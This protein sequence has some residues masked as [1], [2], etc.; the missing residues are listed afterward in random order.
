MC[1]MLLATGD[2]PVEETLE[3]AISMA[4]GKTCPH[5]APSHDHPHG[6]G[7]V[8]SDSD[9]PTGYT[10]FKSLDPLGIQSAS[11]LIAQAG[12]SL[13]R[14]RLLAV[15]ARYATRPRDMGQQFSHPLEA[16]TA[17]GR[18]YFM[19]N[20]FLPFAYQH[21]GLAESRFDT[22]E[23]FQLVQTLLQANSLKQ[24]LPEILKPMGKP[25]SAANMIFISG[26]K[27]HVFNWWPQDH[28]FSDYFR[29]QVLE[30]ATH[31]IISS[32]MLPN[33][34]AQNHWHAMGRGTFMTFNLEGHAP[35]KGKM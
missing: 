10:T 26:T 9:R 33:L 29:M 25:S 7:L 18:S 8:W 27:A 13:K 24:K 34:A 35:T 19:H 31:T 3:A 20:G 22:A 12:P 1:R 28:E 23:Y 16:N 5:L 15:H 11:Q 30:R 2:F 21:L 32:D 17:Q 6:F 14:T 4:N